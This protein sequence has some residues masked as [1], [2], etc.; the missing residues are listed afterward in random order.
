MYTNVTDKMLDLAD[1]S[2]KY[3]DSMDNFE[4]SGLSK[5]YL[6][7][8]INIFSIVIN[9]SMTVIMTTSSRYDINVVK[10]IVNAINDIKYD[11]LH[12]KVSNRKKDK[13]RIIRKIDL[14]L[15]E[16]NYEEE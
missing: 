13:Y 12:D 15:K 11:L 16:I 4:Y 5:T 14:I 6:F 2:D 10:D 7:N 9:S 8:D 3:F 1:I